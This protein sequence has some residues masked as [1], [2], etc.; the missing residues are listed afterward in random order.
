MQYLQNLYFGFDFTLT[1]V[2]LIG[3]AVL[4][5][6]MAWLLYLS[7][8]RRVTRAAARQVGAFDGNPDTLPDSSVPEPASI[9]VYVQDQAEALSRLLPQL[10]QQ[11]YTPGYEIIVVNEG[12]SAATADLVNQLSVTYPNIYLTYTPDGARNLSRKKLGLMLGIKAA[13]NRV[14][15]T[16]TANAMIESP[17]WLHAMMSNFAN[18]DTEVVIG[19]ALPDD[20]DTAWGR[21][22]RAFDNAADAV[23]WLTAA[24]AGKPYRGT[25][26][27][28][29]YTRKAFFDNKGFSNSLNLRY[30]DDDIFVNE[31]ARR[32]NTAVELSPESMVRYKLYNHARE[33]SQLA[34]RHEFTGRYIPK[35]SRRLMA[36]GAWLLWG[37][38]GCAVAAAVMTWPNLTMTVAAVVVIVTGM[39][40]TASVWRKALIALGSRRMAMTLPWL[41]LTL[42]LRNGLRTLRCRLHKG[43]NYTWN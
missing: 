14:V 20:G 37:M 39:W 6:V 21:R 18:P 30:G 42:P 5:L 9:V 23:T 1:S 35:S 3:A 29:A 25:E 22:R 43:R 8:I 2:I 28:L 26:F 38:I 31:I 32:G 17:H 7:R 10:L 19:Y 36:L 27:N 12:E 40:L 16:T 11:D 34:H 24:L 13:R 15:V 33:L 4:C 41:A